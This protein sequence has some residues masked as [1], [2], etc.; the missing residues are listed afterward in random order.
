MQDCTEC[1]HFV[2]CEFPKQWFHKVTETPCDEFERKEKTNGESTDK[3][4]P[5][6]KN[7]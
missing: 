6:R 5:K 2:W 4:Y 3:A 7:T 1:K